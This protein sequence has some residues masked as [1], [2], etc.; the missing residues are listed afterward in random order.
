MKHVDWIRDTGNTLTTKSGQTVRVLELR[1]QKDDS[2]LSAWAKHFRNHYCS[3]DEI[4]SLIQ[5]TK[6]SEAKSEWN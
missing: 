2:V 3:D 1:H 6:Y 4:D 5:G